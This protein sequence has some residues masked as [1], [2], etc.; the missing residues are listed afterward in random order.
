VQ[1]FSDGKCGILHSYAMQRFFL[2]PLANHVTVGGQ[3]TEIFDNEVGVLNA[4]YS[5]LMILFESIKRQF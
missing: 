2:P 4:R 1:K 3:D 5:Q